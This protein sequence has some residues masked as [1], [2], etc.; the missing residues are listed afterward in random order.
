MQKL[1]SGGNPEVNPGATSKTLSHFNCE[2][3]RT[4][5]G[6]NR[7][8]WQ[9]I[10]PW[11]ALRETCWPLFYIRSGVRWQHWPLGSI[12]H[13]VLWLQ[14]DGRRVNAN[15]LNISASQRAKELTLSQGLLPAYVCV[16]VWVC[17]PVCACV[18]V[19][20]SPL[21]GDRLSPPQA[22]IKFIIG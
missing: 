16:C 6:K 19:C 11:G 5:F 17:A 2:R 15:A 14:L 3:V 18:C 7:K 12:G 8:L 10:L 1:S 20:E 21:S 22:H 13:F 9:I 4:K